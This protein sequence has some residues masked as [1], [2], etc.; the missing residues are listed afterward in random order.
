MYLSEQALEGILMN[1]H[2]YTALLKPHERILAL[3]LPHGGH[4]SHG[5]QVLNLLGIY[6]VVP[7]SDHIIQ[8]WMLIT[9]ILG[10]DEI[11]DCLSES[12]SDLDQ[13]VDFETFL[14]EY[15]NL[16]VRATA[17]M[18]DSKTSS[19]FLKATTTTLRHT[20]SESEKSSYVSIS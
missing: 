17:K 16:Q 10:E 6:Y 4:L 11:R 3:D 2:V 9:Q 15:V 19:S 8:K 1:F 18:G 14:R 13:E 12:S 7:F 5:Y 20:I